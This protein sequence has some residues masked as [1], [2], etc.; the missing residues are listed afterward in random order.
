MAEFA[1]RFRSLIKRITP[2]P[3]Q[4]LR[5][6]WMLAG[7]RKHYGTLSI[8]QAFDRIYRSKAWGAARGE[9]FCSGFGSDQKFA[10]PYIGWV[11]RFIEQ[12]NILT[13]V[14][15]GC[16]DFRIGRQICAARGAFHYTGLDVV[17]DLITHNQSQFGGSEI[18]G[19]PT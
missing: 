13:V 14:D 12:N 19:W 11:R 1:V 6:R 18:S 3:L 5:I 9:V 10:E 2:Q 16:G 4:V 7:T 17:A 8:A 15:L